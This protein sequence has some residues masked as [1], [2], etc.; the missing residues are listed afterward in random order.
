LTANHVGI[1]VQDGL[2][3]LSHFSAKNENLWTIRL[4]VVTRCVHIGGNILVAV[5]DTSPSLVAIDR[6][7]GRLL[8]QVSL[9]AA[10]TTAP[11]VRNNRILLGT[12]SGVDSRSL[13]D[14][15]RL[16]RMA[17]DGISGLY[18]DPDKYVCVNANGHLIVGSPDH[19]SVSFRHPGAVASLNP[20]VGRNDI[21]FVG[22]AGLS[23]VRLRRE[24]GSTVKQLGLL[25]V[26]EINTP[27]VLHDGRIY[28]GVAGRGLVCLGG[29]PSR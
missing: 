5:V 27:L 9:D 29:E 21:V 24:T 28:V 3:T 2:E 7:S 22:S 25:D 13:V 10:P 23:R 1:F 11:V 6:P 17:D 14:G 18:V 4:G 12:D 8:W 26:N 20:L 15:R 19:G 16:W